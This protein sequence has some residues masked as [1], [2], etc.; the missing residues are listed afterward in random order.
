M[1]LRNCDKKFYETLREL[2]YYPR[3]NLYSEFLDRWLISNNLDLAN[4]SKFLMTTIID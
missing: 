4:I 1:L 3:P 2:K